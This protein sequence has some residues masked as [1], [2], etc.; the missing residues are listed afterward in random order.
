MRLLDFMKT[1]CVSSLELAWKC[2]QV[3]SFDLL[4]GYELS[5]SFDVRSFEGITPSC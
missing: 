5:M 3:P 2:V 1:S 4:L